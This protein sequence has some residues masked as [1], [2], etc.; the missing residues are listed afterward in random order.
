MLS[1]RNTFCVDSDPHEQISKNLKT[2][3]KGNKSEQEKDDWNKLKITKA[4][5]QHQGQLGQGI[6]NPKKLN[7]SIED[8]TVLSASQKYKNKTNNKRDDSNQVIKL[9]QI[10]S[11]NDS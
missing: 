11:S 4:E 10:S 5:E 7:E 8:D 9:Q 1:T 3:L 6:D 2:G